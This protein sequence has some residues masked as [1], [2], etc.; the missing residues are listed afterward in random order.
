MPSSRRRLLSA[1]TDREYGRLCPIVSDQSRVATTSLR[2]AVN[3][4]VSLGT[5]EFF[6]KSTRIDTL[7]GWMHN[8]KRQM[9]SLRFS[10]HTT[11]LDQL[12]LSLTSVMELLSSRF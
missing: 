3:S 12:Q 4:R 9:L 8:E 5:P 2:L 1:L 10:Q 11:W 7:S 6:N